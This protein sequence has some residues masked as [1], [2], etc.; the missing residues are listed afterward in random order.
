MLGG[1]PS[2]CPGYWVGLSSLGH[3]YHQELLGLGVTFLSLGHRV[4]SADCPY[5]FRSEESGRLKK[6]WR[7]H[8]FKANSVRNYSCDLAGFSPVSLGFGFPIPEEAGLEGLQGPCHLSKTLI[9]K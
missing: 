7:K 2:A 9:L 8:D 4:G 5:T 1:D 6:K 3:C